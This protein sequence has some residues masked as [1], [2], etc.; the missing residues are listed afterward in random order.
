MYVAHRTPLKQVCFVQIHGENNDFM[1]TLNWKSTVAL[2]FV[3]E[4]ALG[5]ITVS[6]QR[7]TSPPKQTFSHRVF[8]VQVRNA[9]WKGCCYYDWIPQIYSGTGRRWNN[10]RNIYF[11]Y[12]KKPTVNL[13]TLP[14]SLTWSHDWKGDKMLSNFR[15]EIY[16]FIFHERIISTPSLLQ[17]YYVTST[18]SARALAKSIRQRV[19]KV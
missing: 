2:N 3:C 14:L 6:F 1:L 19:S 16:G 10:L 18:S 13:W 15:S 12:V 7:L 8:K 11:V 5:I 9:I 4:V 17:V